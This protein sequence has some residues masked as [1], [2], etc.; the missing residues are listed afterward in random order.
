MQAHFINAQQKAQEPRPHVVHGNHL[1]GWTVLQLHTTFG[2]PEDFSVKL[3]GWS[4]GLDGAEVAERPPP[5]TLSVQMSLT[6]QLLP[7]HPNQ[8]EPPLAGTSKPG[9]DSCDLGISNWF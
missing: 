3:L 2:F 1:Q 7:I 5:K 6:P 9:Q 8:L 4:R